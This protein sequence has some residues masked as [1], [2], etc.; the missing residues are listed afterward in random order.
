MQYTVHPF[1]EKSSRIAVF[2]K[3]NNRPHP[4]RGMPMCRQRPLKKHAGFRRK[5]VP[6]PVSSECLPACSSFAMPE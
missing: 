1:P 6:H 3:K 4:V 5:P 2:F